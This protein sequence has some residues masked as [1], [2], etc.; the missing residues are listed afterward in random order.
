[1]TTLYIHRLHLVCTNADLAASNAY[2][3]QL[4]G[5]PDDIYTFSVPIS[6]NGEEP[7]THWGTSTVATEAMRVQMWNDLQAGIAPPVLYL[8]LDSLS[9]EF[10]GTN[11]AGVDT[12]FD[13]FLNDNGLQRVRSVLP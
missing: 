10:R 6:A 8:W 11:G 7:A 4:T 1:M 5:N 3:E 9:G 2:A 12:D 13:A